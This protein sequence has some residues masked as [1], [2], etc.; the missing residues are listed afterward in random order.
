MKAESHLANIRT[1]LLDM[2]GVLWRGDEPVEGARRFFEILTARGLSYGLLTNNSSRTVTM[3]QEKLTQFGWEVPAERIFTSGTATAAYLQK[4]YPAGMKLYVIGEPGLKTMI[5][6]AGFEIADGIGN[7]A[8]ASV[9]AVVVGIDWHVT[10]D[11][12]AAAS[13]LI[14]KGAAYIGTNPDRSFPTADGLVPGT[15]ALLAAVEA[16]TGVKPFVVGKPNSAMFEV[17]LERLGAEP[18]TTTMIGDRLETDILGGQRA[19]LHTIG[20]L[21]GVT[22][23]ELLASS[24]IQPDLVFEH[25]GALADALEKC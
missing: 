9:E 10:Y 18:S 11:K 20:V 16:T 13:R 5:R 14:L 23:P 1:F 24:S 22:S 2:D 15:G 12:L 25:L 6:E 4:R 7:D 3:Y 8:P 19:G 17:A 21:S